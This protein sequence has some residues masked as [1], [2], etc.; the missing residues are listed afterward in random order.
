MIQIFRLFYRMKGIDRIDQAHVLK[1][2]HRET[3]GNSI[4]RLETMTERTVAVS[5]TSLCML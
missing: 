4:K 1:N 5:F 3:T 2:V